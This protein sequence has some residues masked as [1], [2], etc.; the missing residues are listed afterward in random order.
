MRYE[1]ADEP[2]DT[3][4]V[5]RCRAYVRPAH[6]VWEPEPPPRRCMRRGRWAYGRV[7][8]CGVH[9]KLAEVE[10]AEDDV[11]VME[12]VMGST[13]GVA[14]GMTGNPQARVDWPHGWG[15][16]DP[17]QHPESSMRPRRH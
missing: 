17:Y 15:G 14:P 13:D 9:A 1:L 16:S 7:L 8:L 10:I 6:Y 4:R 2:I 5:E 12:P 11:E 3:Y